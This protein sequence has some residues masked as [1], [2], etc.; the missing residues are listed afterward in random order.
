MPIICC[1]GLELSEPISPEVNHLT[2]ENKTSL[3]H[4]FHKIRNR[5]DCM[6]TQ[7][8]RLNADMFITK[9]FR[10]ASWPLK[11]PQVTGGT[12]VSRP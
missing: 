9:Y 11:L 5:K 3:R 6:G 7:G 8:I 1:K 4:R 2:A 12:A 10:Y